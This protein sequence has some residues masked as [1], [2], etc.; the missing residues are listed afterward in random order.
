[1]RDAVPVLREAAGRIADELSGKG[2]TRI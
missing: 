2:A 1:V